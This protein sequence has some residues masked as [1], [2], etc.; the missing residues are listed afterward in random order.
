MH[1][2]VEVA[3]VG[4]GQAGLALGYYLK[5]Q[6]REFAILEA[7]PEIGLSWRTRWDS[8]TLFTP[9]QL[10]NL[11]GL[12]FPGPADHY[13]GKDEVADYIAHYAATCDIPVRLGARVTSL[14]RASERY[15]LESEAGTLEAE[16]VVVATCPFACPYRPPFAANVSADVF[17]IHSSEYRNP[18][19]LPPGDVLIVG[20]G[21]SGAQIAEELCKARGVH[22]SVGKKNPYMPQRI[23]GRDV[24]WW[25]SRLGLTNVT[26]N[27]HLGKRLSR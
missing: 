5:Q 8:L 10:S 25:M 22:L 2:S 9:S 15:V 24:F 4:G 1:E 3:V 23:A 17:N 21:T 14:R 6:G 12:A 11:P 20:A 26:I 16:Q 18:D 7:A 13:S 27:S 19:Q